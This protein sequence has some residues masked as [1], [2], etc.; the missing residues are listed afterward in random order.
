MAYTHCYL[1]L[2]K[3]EILN[4]EDNKLAQFHL[5]YPQILRITFQSISVWK[6]LKKIWFVISLN[7]E[8]GNICNAE[9]KP[10]KISILTKLTVHVV[11][12]N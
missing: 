6:N 4:N 1:N 12:V 9:K 11:I 5:K 3:E 8:N 10:K 2:K 7:Q